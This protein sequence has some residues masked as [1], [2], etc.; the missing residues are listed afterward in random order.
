[1][2]VSRFNEFITRRLLEGALDSFKRHGAKEEDIDI[3]WTPGCFE[4]PLVAKKMAE[5]KRYD[6]ILCLGAVIRGS[7]PTSSTL[8]PK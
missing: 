7:T 4:I 2:V 3:L 1:V 5:Q 6:A 8:L